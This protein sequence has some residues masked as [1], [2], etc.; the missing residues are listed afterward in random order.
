MSKVGAVF[1]EEEKAGLSEQERTVLE[2]DA[3]STTEALRKIAG[4]DEPVEGEGD[5]EET[6]VSSAPGY[7]APAPEKYDERV[8]EF[9][10]RADEVTA[11]FQSGEIELDEMVRQQRAI[12]KERSQLDL[13]MERHRFTAELV[14]QAGERRWSLE[15]RRFLRD[16]KKDEG[17]DYADSRRLNTALDAEVKAL[18]NDPK[19]AEKSGRWFLTEAHKRVQGRLNA[20]GDAAAET[21]S[22]AAEDRG[23]AGGDEFGEANALM[24]GG[25]SLALEAYIARQSPEWQERWAQANE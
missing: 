15:I 24:E 25:D 6:D 9:D 19:N 20:T 5:E 13:Q 23:S 10:S 12:D 14:E 21:D 16:V 4:E 1:T 8:M 3:E 22:M 2:E 18:A 7:I 17:I 11:K